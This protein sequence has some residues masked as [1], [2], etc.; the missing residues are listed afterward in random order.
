M[1]WRLST[2]NPV[3]SVAGSRSRV[4][5]KLIRNDPP[6]TPCFVRGTLAGLIT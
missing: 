2:W 5:G 4:D 1:Q 6:P 3:A